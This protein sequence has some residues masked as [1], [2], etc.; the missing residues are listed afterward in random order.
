MFGF[1]NGVIAVYAARGAEVLLD[2]WR[3]V[4]GV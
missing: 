2:L 4:N 3:L 1:V